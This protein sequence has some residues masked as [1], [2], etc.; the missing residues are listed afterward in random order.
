MLPGSNLS[1]GTFRCA[2]PVNLKIN[3]A[4]SQLSVTSLIDHDDASNEN[5]A[6]LTFHNLR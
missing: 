5:N 6:N 2:L 1:A 4:C 3:Y